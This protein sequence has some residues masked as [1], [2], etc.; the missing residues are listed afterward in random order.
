[1][2]RGVV[3]CSGL[4]VLVGLP[5]EVGVAELS[6]DAKTAAVTVLF[7]VSPVGLLGGLLLRW[8]DLGFRL[9]FVLLFVLPFI[10]T[11][12]FAL[13]PLAPGGTFAHF[14]VVAVRLGFDFRPD[15]PIFLARRRALMLAT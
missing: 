11:F 6:P 12:N 7:D 13:P 9:L 14:L 15:L 8:L 2:S 1:M 4:T 3:S 10:F 5:C